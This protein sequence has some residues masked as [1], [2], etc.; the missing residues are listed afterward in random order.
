MASNGYFDSSTRSYKALPVETWAGTEDSAGY[1][2]DNFTTWAG[3]ASDTVT[4][5]TGIFD[6]GKI[7]FFNPTV[8]VD[9][10]IPADITIRHGNT[11]DSSGGAIDSPTTVNLTPSTATV[12]GIKARFFEFDITVTRDSATQADPEIFSI[13]VDLRNQLKTVTQ[14]DLD[15]STLGGST[16]ARELTFNIS[17]GK[18]TNLLVQT[19]SSTLNTDSAGDSVTPMVFIDK[20]STPPILNIF[21]IDTYGK[22]TRV[23]CVVDVQATTL[24]LLQT[25]ATGSIVEVND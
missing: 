22:R 12:A 8:L 7:D 24:P 17:T 23:D 1:T 2:W 19:H 14:S 15:T 9:S 4:F 21:N 16:G 6:G 10:S 13:E 5:T 25:D 18:I 11:K 3:T 20:S